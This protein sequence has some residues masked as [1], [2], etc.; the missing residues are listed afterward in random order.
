MSAA[1]H[2]Y[3][4]ASAEL[5]VLCVVCARKVTEKLSFQCGTRD[6]RTNVIII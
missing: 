5:F 1:A 3:D 6:Q 2:E 4:A